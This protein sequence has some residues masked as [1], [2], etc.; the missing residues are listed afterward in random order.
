[1]CGKGERQ[2]G[3]E[4]NRKGSMKGSN[5]KR[6]QWNGSERAMAGMAIKIRK[7][8]MEKGTK[9]ESVNEGIMTGRVRNWKKKWRIIWVYAEKNRLEEKLQT[10]EK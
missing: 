9:I 6:K 7:E 5:R 1:M 8:I 3:T 2:K 10:L 4:K